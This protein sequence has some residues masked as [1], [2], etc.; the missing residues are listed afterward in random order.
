M[1]RLLQL[2]APIFFDKAVFR[3]AHGPDDTAH[4]E[5]VPDCEAGM[6]KH[7]PEGRC[8][9][10]NLSVDVRNRSNSDRIATCPN[11]RYRQSHPNSGQ[12]LHGPIS[13][14]PEGR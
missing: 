10:D 14:I 2:D 5:E 1:N 4:I 7:Q 12:S 13:A 6:Q 11:V 3:V 8:S 9:N